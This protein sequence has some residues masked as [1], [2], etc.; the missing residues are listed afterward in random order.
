MSGKNQVRNTTESAKNDPE[1]M[2]MEMMDGGTS[3]AIENQEARG[4]KELV[5]SEILPTE[6][7]DEDKACLQTHGVIFADKV[8]DDPIFTYVTL[9]DGWAKKSTDH[10]M[11]SYLLDANGRVRAEIFY[12]A[13]YYDRST[14]MRAT[15]RYG[16]K[17]DYDARVNGLVV[18]HAVD[19]GDILKTFSRKCEDGE[20]D[21]ECMDEL[22]TE[23]KSWLHQ[24]YP[25]WKNPAKY[26]N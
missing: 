4:Q 25:D 7:T 5:N 3:K 16:V 18:V 1:L 10:S 11:W 12:K 23:A 24:H 9:P 20:E 15:V 22:A 13:A 21:Y 17:V 6:I 19:Q 2:L 14:F 8:E 26:W